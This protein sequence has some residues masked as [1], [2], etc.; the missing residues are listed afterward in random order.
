MEISTLTQISGW[1]V[2]IVGFFVTTMAIF[3]TG[4][5]IYYQRSLSK[6]AKT[7]IVENANKKL[8]EALKNPDILEKFIKFVV[9]SESFRIRF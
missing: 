5:G 2:G 1:V 9:E 4:F 8:D 7:A 3:I 6:N